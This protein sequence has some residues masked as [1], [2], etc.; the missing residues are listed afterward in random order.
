M[1][2]ITT[3]IPYSEDTKV[4]T[5]YLNASN[6]KE[7][8]DILVEFNEQKRLIRFFTDLGLIS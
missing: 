7:V 3:I 1:N 5:L 2:I 4:T 6:V 8:K